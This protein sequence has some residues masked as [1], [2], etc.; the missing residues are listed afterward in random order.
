MIKKGSLVRRKPND[1]CS[2]SLA[3]RY[4]C[5]IE[6]YPPEREICIVTANPREADL[7]SHDRHYNPKSGYIALKRSIEMVCNGK[8]YGPCDLN[9]FDEVKKNEK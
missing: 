7:S 6:S 4:D 1:Y 2:L 8:W 3:L 5:L 9:A